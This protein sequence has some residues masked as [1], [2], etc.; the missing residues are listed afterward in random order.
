M[1]D[2]ELKLDESLV[3]RVNSDELNKFKTKCEKA[4]KPYPNMIREII[5]A[6]NED[7]INII[8]TEEQK[9]LLN[10]YKGE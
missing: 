2:K 3:V 9:E 5:T 4:K 1:S 10:I 7:R 6:F 8:P